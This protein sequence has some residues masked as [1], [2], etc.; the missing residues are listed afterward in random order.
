MQKRKCI[1][2]GKEFNIT[3]SEEKFYESKGFALPKRCK[4]CRQKNKSRNSGSTGYKQSRGNGKSG[5]YAKPYVHNL[6]D[7]EQYKKS[8]G[9]NKE[10]TSTVIEPTKN[11]KKQSKS[12]LWKVLVAVILAVVALFGVGNQE[13]IKTFLGVENTANYDNSENGIPSE[14]V[15]PILGKKESDDGLK[16]KD[17]DVEK[18]QTQSW[19]SVDASNNQYTFRSDYYLTEHFKKHGD[20]FA[21]SS[22]DEYLEGANQVIESD[23]A[24]HKTE[25]EDGDDV[26]YLEKTNEFVIVST[27]G[28]IRTYFKPED[29]L[30]YYNRQ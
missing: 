23:E 10:N 21:Y 17:S 29:G 12:P 20:E 14:N 26:Y 13:Q 16:Q 19:D 24:L 5:N 18:G 8:V 1:Q 30:D 2:C 15:S 25:A 27:D 4:F 9:S 7:K 22:E 28:Y 3:D 6:G 11:E